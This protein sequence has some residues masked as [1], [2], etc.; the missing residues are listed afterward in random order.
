MTQHDDNLPKRYPRSPRLQ[1]YTAPPIAR[2]AGLFFWRAS[3]RK[4][5]LDVYHIGLAPR[6]SPFARYHFAAPSYRPNTSASAFMISPT[7]QRARAASS[8]AG[9]RLSAVAATRRTAASDS[10]TASL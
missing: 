5:D 8:S 4:P 7:A 1:R 2:S 10:R 3:G 6:R 9:I